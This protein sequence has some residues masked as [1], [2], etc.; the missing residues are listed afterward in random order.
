MNEIRRE[1]KN[2]DMIQ[3]KNHISKGK[4]YVNALQKILRRTDVSDMGKKG[5][6]FT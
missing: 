4:D 3:N 6:V 2:G 5:T 1:M